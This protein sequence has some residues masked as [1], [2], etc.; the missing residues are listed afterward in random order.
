MEDDSEVAGGKFKER[1]KSDRQADREKCVSTGRV[2]VPYH[3]VLWCCLSTSFLDNKP[4]S[5]SF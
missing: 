1:R 2:I 3:S 4:L 5:A